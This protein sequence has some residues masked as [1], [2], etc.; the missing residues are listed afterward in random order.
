MRIPSDSV[1][2]APNP[3]LVPDRAGLT[4]YHNQIIRPIPRFLEDGVWQWATARFHDVPVETQRLELVHA[5]RQ[6]TRQSR[7]VCQHLIE[8]K[9]NHVRSRRSPVRP[10]VV[11]ATKSTDSSS[12][13]STIS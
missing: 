4:P 9:V 1:C 12:T 10:W 2:D 7:V 11:I 6:V 8:W 13:K 5:G 3:V